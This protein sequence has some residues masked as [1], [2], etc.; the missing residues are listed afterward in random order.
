MADGLRVWLPVGLLGDHPGIRLV[1]HL[2]L[3]SR[4]GWDPVTAAD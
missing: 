4:A 2:H 1:R 3:E